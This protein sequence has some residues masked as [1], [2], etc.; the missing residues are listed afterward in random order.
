[1]LPI[2]AVAVSVI[3]GVVT[4]PAPLML[5]PVL[6]TETLP[7]VV[8][9]EPIVT[10]VDPFKDTVPEDVVKVPLVAR[11]PERD[12]NSML[13]VPVLRLK[14]ESVR[15]VPATAVIPVLAPSVGLASV[16]ALAS[17]MDTVAP[18]EFKLTEPVKSLLELERL[19]T[20]EPALNVAAPAPAAW[21]IA[22]LWVMPAAVTIRVPLPKVDVP[23]SI[24]LVSVMATLFAPEL[25]KITEPVKLLPALARVITPAPALKVAVPAEAA[26][27]IAPVCVIPTAVTVKV[28][29]PTLVAPK[30]IAFVSVIATL[31][32]P[33]FDKATAPPKSFAA[34]FSVIAKLPV[35]KLDVPVGVIPPLA[36]VIAPPAV[37]ETFRSVDWRSVGSSYAALG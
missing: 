26:W 14:A 12:W 29:L 23:K 2:P 7:D 33:L 15:V 31:L 36:C 16:S 30:P 34:S 35:V 10:P 24:A 28:P 27:V 21:V 5:P 6:R 25:L 9:L 8:M 11:D 4:R 18:V 20:P 37:T 13:P 32:A 3:V 22:A 1:M 17:L 19:I